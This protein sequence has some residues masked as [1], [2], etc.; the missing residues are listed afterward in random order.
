MSNYIYGKNTCINS[1]N[2]ER[3]PLKVL[4]TQNNADIIALCNKYSIKYEITT[5]K[6]LDKISVGKNHQGV[7]AYVPEFE[8]SDLDTLIVKCKDKKDPLILI[9]DGV[10]DPV[11]F[12]SLIRTSSCFNVD[13][14][15]ISKD[16]QVQVTSTVSKVATGAEEYV[17]IVRVTNINVTIENLKKSGFWIVAT[18][19]SGTVFHDEIDYSGPIAVIVGSEGKGI[20]R[21]V[22]KNS[23]Y[24]V[25]IPISGPITSLNASIAGA[26][27]ISQINSYRRKQ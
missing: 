14:I 24:V 27:V 10:E 15:I 18:D 20:S 9:L 4:L 11:N 26:I 13:G 23:D 5:I 19:G 25:R 22:L 16:R 17:P 21:L 8:Y 7:L 1:I 12:G 6:N 3:K 2:G